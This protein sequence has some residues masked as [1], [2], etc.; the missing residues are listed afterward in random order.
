[1]WSGK[2]GVNTSVKNA[3]RTKTLFLPFIVFRVR[4]GRAQS[5]PARVGGGVGVGGVGGQRS[6][7]PLSFS[8]DAAGEVSA[9]VIGDHSLPSPL[10]EENSFECELRATLVS[11]LMTAEVDVQP[12]RRAPPPP[13]RCRGQSAR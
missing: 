12:A 6:E 2:T 9:R 13:S 10:V 1:M 3:E 7:D 5:M 8:A 11:A 4:R